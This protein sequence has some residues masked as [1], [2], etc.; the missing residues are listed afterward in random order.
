[1]PAPWPAANNIIWRRELSATETYIGLAVDPLDCRRLCLC[2]SQGALVVLRFLNI[3][4]DDVDLRQ[5]R[6]GVPGGGQGSAGGGLL[7]LLLGEHCWLQI[8]LPSA[9][10]DVPPSDVDCLGVS[11]YHADC[12]QHLHLH[13][14]CQTLQ[15]ADTTVVL[16]RL[17][18]C[19]GQA[20]CRSAHAPSHVL[21]HARPAFC[22]AGPR[23]GGVRP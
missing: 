13:L 10:I 5:Y 22:A 23:A 9:T 1:M 15:H 17:Y 21:R 12:V 16:L 6:V 11:L 3:D 14:V 19:R 7:S 2:G 4:K 8:S 20:R 18:C